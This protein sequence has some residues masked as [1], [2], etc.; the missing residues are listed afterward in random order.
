MRQ[1]LFTVIA[2]MLLD[3]A[4]L[5]QPTVP[6]A[7][8]TRVFFDFG[9]VEISSDAAQILDQVVADYRHDPARRILLTGHSDRAGPERINLRSSQH[10]AD[11]VRAYL[12]T[13][14]VPDRSI[15]TTAFGEARPL[16]ETEDGVREPQNRRVEI[17]FGPPPV[18]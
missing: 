3:A 16:V 2:A 7:P 15:S 14:G 4:A 8:S 13:R 17:T 9:K 10:R 5:S 18:K 1:A 6:V 12:V 11:A